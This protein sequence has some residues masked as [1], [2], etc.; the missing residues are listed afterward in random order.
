MM[1]L[2]HELRWLLLA[3]LGLGVLCGFVARRFG[4]GKRRQ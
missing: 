3:A 1:Y 4:H 2:I